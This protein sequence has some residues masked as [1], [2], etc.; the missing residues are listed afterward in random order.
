M[1]VVAALLLLPA[2][3]YAVAPGEKTDQQFMADAETICQHDATERGETE[4][5]QFA[6]CMERQRD[7]LA[8][9]TSHS[10]QYTQMFYAEVSYPYCYGEWTNRD[11][12]NVRMIAYCLD[13]EI[14]GFKDV[15]YYSGKFGEDRVHEI[16]MPVLNDLHSWR[17]AGNAVKRQLDPAP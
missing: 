1:R 7:G 2:L 11:I 17:A 14:E 10:A 8:R 9:V 3:V 5:R 16:V 6:Y 13:Q 15:R 12:S 4:P